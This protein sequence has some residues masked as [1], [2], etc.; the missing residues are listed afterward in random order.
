M[1]IN[2]RSQFLCCRAFVGDMIKRNYGRIANVASIAGKEGNPNASAYSA[3]KA[4]VI[5]LTKSLAKET[6]GNNISVNAIA[7]VTA[8]TRILE[9]V[10]PGPHRLH[11]V[12]DPARPLRH[13]RGD[14]RDHRLHG[15]GGV[16]L[17]HRLH[18]RHFRRPCHLLKPPSASGPAEP[19]PA[20]RLLVTSAIT[21]LT[22]EETAVRVRGIA[23]ILARGLLLRPARQLRPSIAA[24]CRSLARGRLVPLFRQSGHR[25]PGAAALARTGRT[26]SPDGPGCRSARGLFLLGAT[27]LQLHAPS[28]ICRWP[29]TSSIH[30]RRPAAR[31]RASPD[32]CS[33]NGRARA[34]GPR[35]SSASSAC[36]SS[37]S[38][39][40]PPSIRRP[41]SPSPRRSATPAIRSSTRVLSAT[42]STAGMLDLC[43]GAGD[44]RAD[45]GPAGRR[46]HAADLADRRRAG[47]HRHLPAAS[48]TGS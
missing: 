7:P 15:V 37:S 36:S 24:H 17:H 32:R 2:L 9:Q 31:H 48:A 6:A 11:A 25:R 47:R 10:T 13:R 34:A 30:V 40:P 35:S 19:A 18:L 22:P 26:T 44:D 43:R 39:S 14:R 28:A 27:R 20:G 38:P 29:I 8:N 16:L 45:A 33:A 12:Q 41:C 21:P 5:A 4:G 3:S 46:R 42:D 23:F 1:R